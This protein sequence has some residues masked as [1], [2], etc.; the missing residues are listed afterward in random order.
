MSAYNDLLNK[1]NTDGDIKIKCDKVIRL[2]DLMK[3]NK[4]DIGDGTAF[5]SH[6]SEE[7]S[8]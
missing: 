1:Y 5:S 3:D 2:Y 8:R 6:C 7:V 4:A